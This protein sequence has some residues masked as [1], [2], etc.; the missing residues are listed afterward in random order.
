MHQKAIYLMKLILFLKPII[1]LMLICYGLF[2]PASELP[3]K[4]FLN[5]PYFDKM[6]HFG[7][8]FVFSLLLF[9]PFKKIN[10]NH[11][12]FA[13]ALSLFLGA[14]LEITQH[15][16]SNTRSSNFNDFL[17]NTSGIAFSIVFFRYFISGKRWEKFF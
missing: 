5:I 13:P 7:L 12:F 10:L 17:A 1:W 14:L 11:L 8:F 4:P 15:I 16:I 2:I 6:V 9:R 3:S